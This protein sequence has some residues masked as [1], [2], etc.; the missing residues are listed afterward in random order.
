MEYVSLHLARVLCCVD[1]SCHTAV[2]ALEFAI[3]V[4]VIACPCGIGLAAPTAL[5][6]GAGLAA[7]HGILVRGGGEAFQEAAQLD[8]IVFDKTGTLTTG[9]EPRVTD[10]GVS[11]E[12]IPNMWGPTEKARGL[13]YSIISKL[14]EASSHPLGVAVRQHCERMTAPIHGEAI[15]Q[16]IEEVA[17]R[18][19]KGVFS[20]PQ[21]TAIIGNEKWVEEHGAA[22]SVQHEQLLQRWK[23]EGKSIIIFAARDE[24]DTAMGNEGDLKKFEVLAVFGATD[25]LRPE[26]KGVVA[27]IQKQGLGT[28]MISGDNP[29]TAK[30]VA[31]SVGIPETN[32]IAGVLPHEK[33]EKIVWLQQVGMKRQP[34]R[35]KRIL[36]IKRLNERCIVAMV[37]DG[38]NDAPVCS[39]NVLLLLDFADCCVVPGF[40][41]G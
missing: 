29:I 8:V 34:P 2:W 7:K 40:N 13:M 28:W 27:A 24:G 15:P 38:I 17:G 41:D 37:G 4:F 26:A 21:C 6:V 25:D 11:E 23:S 19:L 32:V 39:R 31:K 33:A 30:A 18:G 14:E 3:A 12:R 22:I 9:G 10:E 1:S 36:G 16:S 5:L 20:T 35:W